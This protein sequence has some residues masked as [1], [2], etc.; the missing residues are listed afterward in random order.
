MT[1]TR[2]G[3]VSKLVYLSTSHTY[4]LFQ[5]SNHLMTLIIMVLVPAAISVSAVT[6]RP[7]PIT[8][9]LRRK[10][11]DDNAGEPEDTSTRSL[12]TRSTRSFYRLPLPPLHELPSFFNRDIPCAGDSSTSS[13]PAPSRSTPGVSSAADAAQ[14]VGGR[15]WRG[16]HARAHR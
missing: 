11:E 10:S 16:P 14:G 5:N 3:V 12:A 7:K 15:R 8:G 1:H 4:Y 9:Q 2:E 13:L 6:Q